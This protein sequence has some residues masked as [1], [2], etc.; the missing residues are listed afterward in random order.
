VLALLGL[1]YSFTEAHIQ[2]KIG[3]IPRKLYTTAEAEKAFGT[4]FIETHPPGYKEWR[5]GS[6]SVPLPGGYLTLGAYYTTVSLGTPPQNYTVL[7][8]TGSSNLA[9]PGVKCNS[10]GSGTAF[11][12]TKSR[13]AKPVPF[14]S[15]LCN[16]CNNDN[17]TNCLF[18]PTYPE[19]SE[20]HICA[21]SL[22]GACLFWANFQQSIRTLS[23]P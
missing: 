19:P 18:G 14:G 4:R 2:H 3:R 8:D 1:L 10:C 20:P 16:V 17:T 13:S 9:I 11:D 5:R 7:Y 12:I 21:H 15:A 22:A 23:H 6:A